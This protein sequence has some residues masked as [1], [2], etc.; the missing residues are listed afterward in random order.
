MRL[1]AR[2]VVTLDRGRKAR[3]IEAFLS[4]AMT[5]S[6][7]A[8]RILDIGYGNGDISAHFFENNFVV[9]IDVQ[10]CSREEYC[11]L[12]KCL[13]VSESLPFAD[14][15]FDIVISH[16][17]IEHVTDHD[18]HLSEIRRVLTD[19]GVCYL[20]T[21]NLTSPFMRGHIDNP[22][23]LHY[24]QMK[25]LFEK[26]YFTVYEYY[27]RWLHEPDRFH[28]ETR[29]FRFIPVWLLY[30]LRKWF[31]SQCFLLWPEAHDTTS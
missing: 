18:L 1:P 13:A 14:K 12:N 4:D 6:V 27:L 11:Y 16:H 28:C 19:T 20:G 8:F 2:P 7:T 23:V 22:M 25:P 3:M 29:I 17:V 24:V 26:H 30:V 31:P 21:P 15:S 5:R 9:S 10:N